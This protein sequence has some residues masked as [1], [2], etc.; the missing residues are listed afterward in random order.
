MWSSSHTVS[1]SAT[2][3]HIWQRYANPTT[4]PAWDDE[5]EWVRGA[6]SLSV[7][8]TGRLKPRG[9][10]ACGFTVTEVNPGCSFTDVTSLPS[11]WLPLARL[12]LRHELRP[13]ADGCTITH[14]LTIT[15]PLAAV[16]ARLVG[17]SIAIHLPQTM[18][19]LAAAH[20]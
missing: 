7:G 19:K 5:L 14:D 16:F 20:G 4:W 12:A 17:R 10:P 15:G 2:A 6:T 1:S 11:R 18:A 9:G 8:A 3:D 13:T